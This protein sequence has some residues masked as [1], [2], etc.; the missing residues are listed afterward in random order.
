MAKALE[1]VLN[2]MNEQEEAQQNVF[3]VKDL[4]T[5]TEAGRRITYINDRM[6]EIDS[7]VEKQLEPFLKKIEMI[8]EWGEEAKKEYIEKSQRYEMLLEM[9]WRSEV[10][11]QGKKAKKSLKLPYGELKLQKQQPEFNRNEEELLEYAKYSGHVKVKESADWS[12]IKK[13]CVVLNGKLVDANGE[14]VPGVEVIE[15]DDKFVFKMA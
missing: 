14:Y 6:S 3:E 7:I 4:E 15:R 1:E 13:D 5:A 11:K 9:Y 10:E 8:K 2:I 12:A